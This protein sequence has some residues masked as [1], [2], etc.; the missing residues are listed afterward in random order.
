MSI[1][2][3]NEFPDFSRHNFNLKNYYNTYINS[4]VV[5]NARS[6]NIHYAD[7]AGPL[8][9]KYVIKGSEYYVTNRCKYRVTPDNF[10]VLNQ[11][12]N[13]ESYIN[14][15]ETVESFAVFFRPEFVSKV[16]SSLITPSDKLLDYPRENNSGAQ[17]WFLEKLYTKDHIIVPLLLS[18]HTSLTHETARKAITEQMYFLLEGLMTTHRN[19]CKEINNIEMVKSST[20]TEIYKRLNNVKDYIESC[21]NENIS[22]D[23]LAKTACMNKYHLLRTFKKI[24]GKT[25]HQYLKSVRLNEAKRLLENSSLS[26]S[27]IASSVGFEFLSTLSQLFH[28]QYKLSPKAYR[29]LQL[30]KKSILSKL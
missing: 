3:F 27:Q 30:P 29:N 18:I 28:H 16:L 11:W 22:L 15:E 13:Y 8:S 14:S 5:V 23:I 21:F 2:I 24:F 19:V 10:L 6:A 9:I 20:K 25:P 17:I 12:Q 4:N 7:H 26:V 1:T